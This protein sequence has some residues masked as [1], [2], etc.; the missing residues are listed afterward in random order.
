[1]KFEKKDLFVKMIKRLLIM[2]KQGRERVHCRTLKRLGNYEHF[3]DLVLERC[4]MNDDGF[5]KIDQAIIE[6]TIRN[7]YLRSKFYDEFKSLKEE[8]DE[9]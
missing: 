5:I 7:S 4:D 9:M 3:V 2:K 6:L 1:M 8:L